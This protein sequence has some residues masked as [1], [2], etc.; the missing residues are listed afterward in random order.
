MVLSTGYTQLVFLI[1]MR[2]IHVAIY[3]VDSAIQLLNN[4]SQVNKR[5]V[6]QVILLVTRLQNI[7]FSTDECSCGDKVKVR[8]QSNL[9]ACKNSR[10]I[11]VY[12]GV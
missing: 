5:R 4:W 9:V 11:G 12:R 7:G 3:P 6:K 1:L 10:K 8:A 2:W